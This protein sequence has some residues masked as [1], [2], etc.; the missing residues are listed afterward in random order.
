MLRYTHIVSLVFVHLNQLFEKNKS[1]N[2]EKVNDKGLIT[3][4]ALLV[5]VSDNLSNLNKMMMMMIRSLPRCTRPSTVGKTIRTVKHFPQLITV[6]YLSWA[7]STPPITSFNSRRKRQ[8]TSELQRQ[9]LRR[10]HK[11]LKCNLQCNTSFSRKF[12]ETKPQIFSFRLATWQVP[13][14]HIIWV[15]SCDVQQRL[16]MWIISYRTNNKLWNGIA[17]SVRRLATSWT[18]RGSASGMGEIFRTQLQ[19]SWGPT[20]LLYDGYRISFRG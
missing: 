6:H 15:D 9:I 11:I 18:V 4:L 17:Q 16:C 8:T 12:P 7:Y 13:C 19:R 14:A 5:G 2:V 20:R 10:L 1:M 3:D